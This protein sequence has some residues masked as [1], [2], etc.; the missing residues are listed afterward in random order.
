MW[1][2]WTAACAKLN[3]AK[4][5]EKTQAKVEENTFILL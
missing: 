2:T 3:I 1:V 5:E 4:V